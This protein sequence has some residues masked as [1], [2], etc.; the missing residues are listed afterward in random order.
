MGRIDKAI[1]W[2]V[3]IAGSFIVIT[4]ICIMVSIL[5]EK[6]WGITVLDGFNDVVARMFVSSMLLGIPCG[7]GGTYLIVKFRRLGGKG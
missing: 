2:F 3:C 6:I 7:V 4:V 1:K 5:L